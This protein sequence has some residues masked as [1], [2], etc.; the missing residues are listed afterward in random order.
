[1][2]GPAG[3]G[4]VEWISGLAHRFVSPAHS[5]RLRNLYHLTRA[6]LTPLT[7]ALHGHFDTDDLRE[8]LAPRLGGDFEILMVHSSVNHM[9]PMYT[10]TPLEL[11]KMLVDL[12][13]PHRTLAMPAFYFG[14]P[15]IGGALAT[16]QQNPRFD[17]RRTPSQMG[18]A[19]EL[20]RRM[21][22]VLCSRHP[23]YRV[24][25]LGPLA[26]ALTQ[27][28]EH[29]D[30]PAGLGT[31][32]HTMAL[33]D[34]CV[35]GIGKPLQVLTQAH[36]T[37]GA[38]GRDFPVPYTEGPAF[39]MT[40]VHG[41]EEIPF[42]MRGRQYQGRFDIWRLRKLLKPGTIREWRFHHVPLFA[43]RAADVSRQLEAAARAGQTLY[44][45][46]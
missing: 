29:A 35:I 39:P 43:T 4:P 31:P 34:T 36:H 30:S 44:V 17:L 26:P 12:V 19:T 28:H 7:A 25:A 9:Q 11:V 33:R 45:P 6:R 10:G 37:E 38:M 20:F 14:D 1:M 15:A 5:A 22:G 2:S 18:L 13:G 21:P 27:G 3:M 8:H 24:A 40:L 23:V 16:F 46:H 32:F 41:T 42:T